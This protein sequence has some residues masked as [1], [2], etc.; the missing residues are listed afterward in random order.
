MNE[1]LLLQK[2]HGHLALLGLA[3]AIHPV[4]TLRRATRA[5]W[6]IQLSAWAASALLALC[7][8]AGWIIY[9]PYREEVK[10]PLYRASR[11]LGELFEIKE[12]L[13]WYILVLCVAGAVLAWAIGR[14][15]NA[16]LI[17]PTRVVYGLIFALTLAVGVMGMVIGS[18][19]GFA[20][21]IPVTAAP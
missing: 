17:G 21:P 12:H 19:L 10:R 7:S 16:F 15:E 11:M 14:R 8:I 13:G 6:R 2:I 20:Y 9:P 4:L 5:T 3:A 18:W 1:I